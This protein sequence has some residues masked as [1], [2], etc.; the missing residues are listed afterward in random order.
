M[1][2]P[3]APPAGL[4]WKYTFNTFSPGKKCTHAAPLPFIFLNLLWGRDICLLPPTQVSFLTRQ[5]PKMSS[6]QDSANTLMWP[7][8]A[9]QGLRPLSLFDYNPVGS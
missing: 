8:P 3:P 7:Y 5:D 2:C 4:A 1:C 6:L 9:H